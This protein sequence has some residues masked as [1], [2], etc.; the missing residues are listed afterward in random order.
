MKIPSKLPY[1]FQNNVKRVTITNGT[2]EIE[3]GC[4]VYN[5]IYEGPCN[6]S[7]SSK[8]VQNAEGLWVPLVGV[9]HIQGDIDKNSDVI[10][11]NVELN[12]NSYKGRGHKVRNPDGSI[13]HTYIALEG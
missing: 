13:N 8:R 4:E 3:D 11:C 7:Q 6:F 9:I 10:S 12:G 5:T 1:V 2:G